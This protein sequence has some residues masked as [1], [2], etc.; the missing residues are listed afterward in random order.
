M[1]S[2]GASTTIGDAVENAPE[3]RTSA[4]GVFGSV[5]IGVA[6]E[7]AAAMDT[8]RTLAQHRH[9][10]ILDEVRRARAVRVSDLA[11]ILGVSDMTVRRDLEALDEAGLLTKVHGGATV[12]TL[13][14]SFEPGFAAKS[15]RNTAEKD[16]IARAAAPLIPE[17]SAIGITAGT[18]TFRLATHLEGIEGLTVITNSMGVAELLTKDDRTDR[19]VILTGGVR[20]PSDAL[21]GPVAFGALRTLHLDMVFMGVHGMAERTGFTTPNLLEAETNRAFI[22]AAR[23]LVVL[24]DHTKWDVTGLAEIVGIDAAHTLVTDDGIDEAARAVLEE[25]IQR[26]IVTSPSGTDESATDGSPL[27]QAG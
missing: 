10:L 7:H 2:S 9:E 8:R 22:A 26:L 14:S 13:Q 17:G 15:L 20:T 23:D 4:I 27:A 19:T 12:P 25:C 16:A 11:Q 6:I 5:D 3:G 21:V 1:R 18:T 24:A